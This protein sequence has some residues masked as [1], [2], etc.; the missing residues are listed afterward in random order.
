LGGGT[1]SAGVTGTIGGSL[2]GST[3][4]FNVSDLLNIF[5]FRPD[6]NFGATIKFL[7]N[8]NVLQ[9]LAEPNLMS[10]NGEP[11]RF[12]A[13]GEF[14]FPVAQASGNATAITIQFRPFGV[15][16]D[17]VGTIGKDDVI[18]LKVAPEVSAL[19]FS[20]AVTVSGSTVPAIST[21][22]AET[23]IELRN[24]Q[25][26]GIAGLLDRRTTAQMSKIPGIGDIPI[27][28]QLF[29]SHN[30]NN[31]ESELLVLVT[32]TIVDPVNQGTPS[33]KPPEFPIPFIERPGFDTDLPG[34]KK[35]QNAPNPSENRP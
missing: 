23:Q 26:F 28:G 29:R 15:K 27:L 18:R 9:V 13:G 24:G 32:P 31:S 6:L 11:A 30:V 1:G 17:F 21:R 35:D 8:K 10:M 12:L 19:D 7:Q 2:S 14:P 3:T 34:Q 20:N 22:R 5:L 4:S 33:Q 25:S 16:L